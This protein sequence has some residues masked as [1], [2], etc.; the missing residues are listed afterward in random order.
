MLDTFSSLLR[1]VAFMVLAVGWL[2][3]C[4]GGGVG[5][6]GTGGGATAT[7]AYGPITGFGSIIVNGIHFDETTAQIED[8]DGQRV[9]REQLLLG[10]T[11]EIEASVVTP[12][13]TGPVATANVVRFASEIVGPVNSVNVAASTFKAFGQTVQVT[14]TTVFDAALAGGLAALAPNLV[15]EVYGQYDAAAQR[16]VATRVQAATSAAYYRLRGAVTALDTTARTLSV[17]GQA[18][19]YANSVPADPASAFAIG[20]VVRLKVRTTPS[21]GVWVLAG[22]ASGEVRLIAGTQTELDGRISSFTSSRLFSVNGVVVDASSASFPKGSSGLA[23]GARVEVAGQ[24]NGNTVVARSVK[25]EDEANDSSEPFELSGRI[26]THDAAAKRFVVRGVTVTYNA[27][28][29]FESSQAADLGVG[30]KV[31]VK[32]ALSAD[33][34]V[35]VASKIQVER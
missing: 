20:K 22:S 28:T 30:R 12:T 3:S 32:G 8:A 25:L 23:L 10:M 19:S 6:G 9:A 26:T 34:T 27:S 1:R 7:S 33:R 31:E 21:N 11:A 29:V 16:V 24:V 13:L 4:G 35:L 2:A 18:F 14:P 5:S 15:I 17:G